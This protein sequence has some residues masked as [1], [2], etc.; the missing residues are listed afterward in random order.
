[1]SK[2]K[3]FFIWLGKLIVTPLKAIVA[4]PIYDRFITIMN[5]HFWL[6]MILAAIVT[7]VIM[8]IGYWI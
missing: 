4:I 8:M 2:V 7:A 6:R 5:K 3:G 1:M